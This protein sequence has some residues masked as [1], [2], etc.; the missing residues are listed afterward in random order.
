VA[1]R[2]ERLDLGV[3]VVLVSYVEPFAV[4][5]FVV[6]AGPGV[7]CWSMLDA[8]GERTLVCS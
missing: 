1:E 4:Q 6:F 2:E 8:L 3:V 7:P 5:N